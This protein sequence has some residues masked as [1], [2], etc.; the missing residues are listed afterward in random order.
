MPV[1]VS[2]GIH[3]LDHPWSVYDDLLETILDTP[4]L[5]ARDG[6]VIMAVEVGNVCADSGTPFHEW[7]PR[8]RHLR[9][10]E[11][12]GLLRGMTIVAQMLPEDAFASDRPCLSIGDPFLPPIPDQ[13]RWL[14][15]TDAI[16]RQSGVVLNLQ[17]LTAQ[18]S[19]FH[20][21]WAELR[22]TTFQVPPPRL[23]LHEIGWLEQF[24]VLPMYQ[25]DVRQ[26]VSDSLAG[27]QS[28]VR[29]LSGPHPADAGGKPSRVSAAPPL[30]PAS[31]G[32]PSLST[33][34]PAAF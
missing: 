9:D 13:S 19:V 1:S 32:R 29:Q 15:R 17:R 23:S 27:R 34:A 7:F 6:L 26:L 24:P 20:E 11:T 28:A 3:C 2:R 18:V 30:P 22:Q 31:P 33:P 10:P 14:S 12:L 5:L 25:M 21:V 4:D 16:L 8:T